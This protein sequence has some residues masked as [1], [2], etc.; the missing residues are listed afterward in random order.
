V[1][2]KRHELCFFEKAHCKTDILVYRG[3]DGLLFQKLK[4]GSSYITILLNRD[5]KYT[6][7]GKDQDTKTLIVEYQNG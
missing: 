7:I 5:G 4:I 6:I 3:V 2:C 1:N